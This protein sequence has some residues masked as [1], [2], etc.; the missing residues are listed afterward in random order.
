V[1]AVAPAVM[2]TSTV[3]LVDGGPD[4]AAA[5][6]FRHAPGTAAVLER[7]SLTAEQVA[8]VSRMAPSTSAAPVAGKLILLER[9]RL[10]AEVVAPAAGVVVV[11]EAHFPRWRAWVDGE[12]A[13]LLPANAGFRG[14]LV[15]PGAHR[16]E[17]EYR[18]PDFLW[19]ALVSILGT[20]AALAWALLGLRRERRE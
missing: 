12:E 19:L 7:R 4:R 15:G 16:I 17:M 11:H 20:L 18:A 5:A 6:L 14:L 2:W 9:N 3:E 10:V 1:A 13:A 8:A